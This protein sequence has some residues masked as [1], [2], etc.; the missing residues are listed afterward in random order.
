MLRLPVKN[1]CNFLERKTTR[2]DEMNFLRSRR[3]ALIAFAAAALLP[4]SALTVQ[5]Q[6]YPDHPISLIVPFPPGGG[7]DI[8]SRLLANKIS[9]ATGWNFVVDNR[10]GA[11]GNIGLATLARA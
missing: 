3:E 7:T 8:L 2:R 10:P 4:F 1:L 11:G 5:A 9:S 6:S